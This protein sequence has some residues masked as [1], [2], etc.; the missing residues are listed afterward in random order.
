MFSEKEYLNAKNPIMYS[1]KRDSFMK[2]KRICSLFFAVAMVLTCLSACGKSKGGSSDD[3]KVLF[4]EPVTFSLLTYE[5]ASQPWNTDA[6]KF[7]EITNATNVTLDINVCSIDDSKTKYV[8][9]LA[10]GQMYDITYM[11]FT[12]VQQYSTSL[13]LDITDYMNNGSLD[14][15]MRWVKD[16]SLLEDMAIDGRYYAF[17]GVNACNYPAS[18]EVELNGMFPVMRTDILEKNNISVPTTWDEW[19]SVMKKLKAI[20]PD[21]TPWSGRA[22]RYIYSNMEYMLGC[23]SDLN[24]DH[25]KG[26]YVI[27]VL[28]PEYR[29]ILEFEKRCYDE[30]I[31]DPNFRNSDS[32]SWNEG[33]NNNKVFFWIDNDGFATSQTLSLRAS[34]ADATM[35]TIP[36]LTD[37][38]GNK[39][40]LKYG[41][42]SHDYCYVLSASSSKAEKMVK[43]MDWCYSDEGMYINNYG[44]E[45]SSYTVNED[46]SVKI[47]DEILQKYSGSTSNYAWMS[48]YG[49]GMLAF[50]PLS[51][52]GDSVMSFVGED[53]IP[54]ASVT[55]KADND[56]GYINARVDITP[57]VT[58]EITTSATLINNLI[59]QKIPQFID[60]SISMTE[61]DSFIEQIKGMG[62]EAVLEAYNK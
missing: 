9:T 52:T 59:Y 60:G 42:I 56:A 62:A 25:T 18:D 8:A 53:I 41:T 51:R 34:N 44:K 16:D 20:Y 23:Q 43:F 39:R 47:S 1:R 28:E 29:S 45:G 48:D 21:S 61:F 5:H 49:L 11:P 33:V 15:Y 12:Y 7:K 57:K 14:N 17:A 46:G 32:N 55:L 4:D 26:K 36:L 3:D 54:P 19:F 13:F 31:L 40:A 10:S 58:D 24:F 38:S 35:E 27:G 50:A 37:S 22:V 30:G 2:I 6:E